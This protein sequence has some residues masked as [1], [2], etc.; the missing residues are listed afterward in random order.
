MAVFALAVGLGT[1]ATGQDAAFYRIVS[2]QQTHIVSLSAAG[3]LVWSNTV[4]NAPCQIQSKRT[5]DGVW[6]NNLMTSPV[7]TTGSLAQAR[8]PMWKHSQRWIVAFQ[9]D[10]TLT[11]AEALFD[12]NELIWRPN[13]WNSL[14]MVLVFIPRGKS[15][16]VVS[17]SPHVRFVEPDIIIV[18]D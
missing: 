10:A 8:V 6:T 14:R 17:S 7:R 16:S 9:P 18:S 3:L 4:P 2:T 11:Q 5:A 1:H 12:A 15:I 13:A